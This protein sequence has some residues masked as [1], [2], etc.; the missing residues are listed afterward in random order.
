[1]AMTLYSDAHYPVSPTLE[2]L[3]GDE[4]QS[5]ARSGTWGTAAQRTAIAATARRAQCEQGLQESVGDEKLAAQATFPDAAIRLA[6]AVAVDSEHIDRK[7]CQDIQAQGVSEGAYVEIVALVARLSNLDVFARGLGIPPR[8][9]LEPADATLPSFE[10]PSE[11]VDEG[12]F[13]AS[14]PSAPKGGLLAESLYGQ[15]PAGNIL[16][17]VS[18]VPDEARRVMTL[19]RQQY[20]SAE[21]LLNFDAPS[22][23]ALSRAQIELIA[24]KVSAHNQ[25]FY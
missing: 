23:H 2:T 12:F 14:V 24:T 16:R 13:T 8:K 4:L 19:V 18:L 17:A 9:L 3:H 11:A 1:M 25:C 10:R 22:D 6:R 15:S 20:F 5:Y 7:F 21:H